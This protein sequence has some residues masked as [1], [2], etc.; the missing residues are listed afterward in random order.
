[1]ATAPDLWGNVAKHYGED[2]AR[3]IQSTLRSCYTERQLFVVRT[4]PELSRPA[5]SPTSEE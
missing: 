1:M 2:E 4:L 5:P 3:H